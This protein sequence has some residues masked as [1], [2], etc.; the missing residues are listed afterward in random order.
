M[1]SQEGIR[2]I[3]VLSGY[4]IHQHL[5]NYKFVVDF[6][7]GKHFQILSP[8]ISRSHLVNLAMDPGSKAVQ[9]VELALTDFQWSSCC[10]CVV[11]KLIQ[12]ERNSKNTYYRIF[13]K[14]RGQIIATENNTLSQPQKALGPQRGH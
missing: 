4:F 13:S 8:I 6:L 14:S 5:D 9:A 1:L 11:L 12:M 10:D 7:T 2:T 3:S